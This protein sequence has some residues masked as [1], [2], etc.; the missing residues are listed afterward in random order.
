MKKNVVRIFV[1]AIVVVMSTS[2]VFAQV[3]INVGTDI[4]SR[5][6]WRGSDFGQS[7]SIQPTLSLSFGS[8][9]FGAWGA[10]QF[11]RDVS[12]PPA[13]EIDLFLG[14][15]LELGESN[16]DFVLT[17]YYFPNAGIK[18]GNFNDSSGAHIVELGGTFSFSNFY[19][20]GFVNVHNDAD[21]SSYFEVGY[22]TSVKSV[23][24]TAFVGASPG[25]V[26]LYYGNS[27]FNVINAG[28]TAS[29]KIKI[30][31]DSSLPIFASYVINPNKEIAHIVLGISL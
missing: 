1:I 20:S 24:L 11:G 18:L 6:L 5:Y 19:L 28:V 14:Y 15:S 31:D 29:K 9:E 26:N 13:D 22:L 30:T 25:G 7:P 27:N 10:Y 4:V 23:D 2:N 17:N 21:N 3:E 16:L 8:F 12:S